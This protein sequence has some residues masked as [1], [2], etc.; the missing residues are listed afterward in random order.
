MELANLSKKIKRSIFDFLMRSL[1]KSASLKIKTA[2]LTIGKISYLDNI[3]YIE[4]EKDTLVLIHGLGADK[5]TWLKFAK[6]LTKSYRII[7][8]DLPGHGL[9]TQDFSIN[10]SVEVQAQC[11]NELLR[12]LKIQ[13]VH[14]I[15]SSMGGAIATKLAYMHPEI[16]SSLILIDSCGVFK[17]PSYAYKLADE[18]GYNPMLE[19]NT[20]DDYKKMMSLAMSKPPFIPGFMLD[21]LTE[22]MKERVELNSKIFR[23]AD[24]DGDQMAILSKIK[25]PSL[26]VWGAQDK[27]LHVDNAEVFNNELQN[28]SKVIIEETGHVPIVEKPKVAA[29]YITNFIHEIAWPDKKLI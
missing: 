1:R 17:T 3:N 28:C 27:I 22:D 11:I 13:H 24:A 20:K 19:I 12:N 23:D 29:K 10:Y 8:L 14:V 25:K 2:L 16:V 15:G 5:D 6:Y 7:A 18:L 9:S 4:K 26:V 21:V